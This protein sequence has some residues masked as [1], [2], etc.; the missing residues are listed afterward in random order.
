M[1]TFERQSIVYYLSPVIKENREG[2]REKHYH[3]LCARFTGP[4]GYVWLQVIGTSKPIE[5]REGVGNVVIVGN[6]CCVGFV[7]LV[8][9]W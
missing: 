8:R 5:N 7:G 3:I 2:R 4:S 9:L 1:A 6:G